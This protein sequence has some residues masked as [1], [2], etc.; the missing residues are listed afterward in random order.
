MGLEQES[1]IRS[2]VSAH[3]QKHIYGTTEH[4]AGIVDCYEK[5]LYG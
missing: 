1:Q 5:T 2:R 4:S 3:G